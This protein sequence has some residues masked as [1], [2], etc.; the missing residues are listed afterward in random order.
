VAQPEPLAIVGEHLQRR[1]FT[2]AENEHRPDEG[3]VLKSFP[4][5]L[6]QAVYAAAEV[7]RLDGH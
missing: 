6:R 5:Q 3:V 4:A 7:G 1:P 2:I